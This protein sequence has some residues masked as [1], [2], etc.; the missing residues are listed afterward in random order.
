[1]YVCMYVCMSVCT[2]VCMCVAVY[3]SLFNMQLVCLFAGIPGSPINVAP[4]SPSD[5]GLYVCWTPGPNSYHIQSYQV[6]VYQHQN[7]TDV[8]KAV[9]LAAESVDTQQLQRCAKVSCAHSTVAC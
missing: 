5:A 8:Y 6:T 7:G 4:Q 2:Y 1:M 3:M 9:F